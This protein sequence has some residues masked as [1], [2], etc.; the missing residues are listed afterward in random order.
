M[1]KQR[2]TLDGNAYN[3]LKDP[4]TTPEKIYGAPCDE[5][6]E[7]LQVDQNFK[8]T[9]EKISGDKDGW[10]K[11][12]RANSYTY[13]GKVKPGVVQEESNIHQQVRKYVKNYLSNQGEYS[14][15]SVLLEQRKL[16]GLLAQ[17]IKENGRPYNI[18]GKVHGT[19]C[20][21]FAEALLDT[22]K[23]DEDKEKCE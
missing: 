9:N 18:V 11:A 1:N 20:I 5:N 16:T 23:E 4:D 19:N 8:A 7:D 17:R 3:L 10:L 13:G 12:S 21:S 15:E 22:I 14:L 2:K 6:V